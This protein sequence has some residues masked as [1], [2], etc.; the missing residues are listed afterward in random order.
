MDA[1]ISKYVQIPQLAVRAHGSLVG[2]TA[3]SI[4]QRLE[5]LSLLPGHGP[6][7]GASVGF[8]EPASR[9]KVGERKGQRGLAGGYASRGR[10][11]PPPAEPCTLKCSKSRSI[12]KIITEVREN[13]SLPSAK[14]RQNKFPA[15]PRQLGPTDSTT[16]IGQ[17]RTVNCFYDPCCCAPWKTFPCSLH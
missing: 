9:R 5:V 14:G 17:V 13:G 4:L 8:R 7:L 11:R 1:R 2:G 3:C 15:K 10:S 6:S 16:E 12:S